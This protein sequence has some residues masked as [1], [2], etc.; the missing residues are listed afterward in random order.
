MKVYTGFDSAWSPNN[1]GAIVSA[2]EKGGQ[3]TIDGPH[4]AN[5]TEAWQH[6][7]MIGADTSYHAIAIDQP[8]IVPNPE[9]QRP[10]ERVAGGV[11]GRRAGGACSSNRGEHEG[12]QAGVQR[13][14]FGDDA[15]IW[16]FLGRLIGIGFEHSYHVADRANHDGKFFFEV[17]PALGNLGLFPFFYHPRQLP[18]GHIYTS[19]RNTILTRPT[20]ASMTGNNSAG[21]CMHSFNRRLGAYG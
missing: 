16:G 18:N 2:V 7:R 13:M 11:V 8:L 14:M 6:I 10:V 20:L 4:I 15:P 1:Q 19:F 9:R 21:P 3:W 5:F 12:S 17:F